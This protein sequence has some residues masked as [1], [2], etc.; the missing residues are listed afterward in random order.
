[1]LRRWMVHRRGQ[2]VTHEM[3]LAGPSL[4]GVAK[5]GCRPAMENASKGLLRT[6]AGRFCS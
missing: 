1:M 6:K 3:P 4:V 5:Y 2:S